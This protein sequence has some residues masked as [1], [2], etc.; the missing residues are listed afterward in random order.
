VGSSYSVKMCGGEQKSPELKERTQFVGKE[1]NTFEQP[2]QWEGGGDRLK[3]Q[4]TDHFHTSA[5]LSQGNLEAKLSK[6]EQGT[7]KGEQGL[8]GNKNNEDVM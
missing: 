2:L 6:I 3:S 4:K 8:V 5:A 7:E 1:K